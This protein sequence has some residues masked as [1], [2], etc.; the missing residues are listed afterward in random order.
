MVN[1]H[2]ICDHTDH[3]DIR[4]MAR[5]GYRLPDV[6]E[7]EGVAFATTWTETN[8]GGR[9]QWFLCPCCDR[10]CAIVYRH[11]DTLQIGC[12]VCLEGRYKS[13]SQ[14]PQDRRLSAAFALRE[15]FGQTEG[16]IL[17]AFP[18]K[19]KGMHWRTYL[20]IR[21]DALKNELEILM[22]AD[23]EGRRTSHKF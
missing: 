20:K 3:V 16:G 8:F 11:P 18:R 1:S 4:K 9:R 12:R 7:L 2:M 21:S 19:P 6:F 14:S 17:V 22:Q 13:E 23:A 15:R 5:L 10:R